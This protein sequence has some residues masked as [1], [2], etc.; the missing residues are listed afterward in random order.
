M[1]MTVVGAEQKDTRPRANSRRAR[2]ENIRAHPKSHRARAE[3]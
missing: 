1:T 3:S 2:A